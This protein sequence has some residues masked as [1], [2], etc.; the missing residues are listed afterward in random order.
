MKNRII[1]RAIALWAVIAAA[2]LP[3]CG[4][5]TED[6]QLFSGTTTTST[7]SSGS[8]STSTSSTSGGGNGSTASTTTSTGNGG[9][10]NGSGGSGVGGNDTICE[11]DSTVS[12]YSGPQGTEGVGACNAGT[13]TCFQDGSAFG[14]CVD[15]VVPAPAENCA[16]DADD[17]C[18]GQINEACQCAPLSTLGCYSGPGNTLGKGLCV[19]GVQTCNANGQGYGPC[20]GEVLPIT[21]DCDGQ[22]D[23]DCDGQVNDGCSCIPNAKALCYSGPQGTDGV[24]ACTAGTQTCDE[25]GLSWGPCTNEIIP[26][27]ETCLTAT[28]DNC[29]GATNEGCVC[30]PNDP[31]PCYDGG[32]GEIGIGTCKGGIKTC[33]ALGTSWSACIGQ[34]LPAQETCDFFDEDCNGLVDDVILAPQQTLAAAPN[35]SDPAIAMV[36]STLG[37]GW[38]NTDTTLPFFS[39]VDANGAPTNLGTIPLPTAPG[40]TGHQVALAANGLG[41]AALYIDTNHTVFATIA[42]NGAVTKSANV[43]AVGNNNALHTDI[44]GNGNGLFLGVWEDQPQGTTADVYFG[45]WGAAGNLVTEAMLSNTNVNATDPHVVWNGTV[46]KV[47]W[48]EDLGAPTPTCQTINVAGLPQGSPATLGIG[49]GLDFHIVWNGTGYA[50]AWRTPGVANALLFARFDVNMA[51]PTITQIPLPNGVTVDAVDLAW[52]NANNPEYAIGFVYTSGSIH[53]ASMVRV[54]TNDLL[55][56]KRDLWAWFGSPGTIRIIWDGAKWVVVWDND[57]AAGRALFWRPVCN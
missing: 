26:V 23:E 37:V 3:G 7:T 18:D 45:L 9:G 13:Q 50:A 4:L 8:G 38:T 33:N 21:E 47:C 49:S 16:T 2:L 34:V 56:E 42:A 24:G 31:Q 44:A 36:G 27:A 55:A 40:M 6:T 5:A 32:P 53:T 39:T 43:V 20:N 19:A 10:G 48:I 17:D 35:V 22:N 15:E 57:T 54:S 51:N 25:N 12:C 28:D 41:Y 52:N 46:Y 1:V 11:P 14:P 30:A 29:N